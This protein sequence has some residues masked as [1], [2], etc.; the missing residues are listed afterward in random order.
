MS[1]HGGG[2]KFETWRVH[3]FKLF[4]EKSTLYLDAKAPE[5]YALRQS[6]SKTQSF[7]SL[8]KEST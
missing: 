2:P 3:H 8:V 4:V 5:N 1:S 7:F 6:I